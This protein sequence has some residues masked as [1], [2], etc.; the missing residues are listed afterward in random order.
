MRRIVASCVLLFWLSGQANAASNK[1]DGGARDQSA[2]DS[3]F[4]QGQDLFIQGQY[5]KAI[6]SFRKAYELQANPTFLLNIARAYERLQQNAQA[7][8]FYE[9]FLAVAD[10]SP[11][12]EQARGRL[13][14]LSELLNKTAPSQTDGAESS[15]PATASHQRTPHAQKPPV[16]RP[17]EKATDNRLQEMPPQR[18]DDKGP[19]A[20][21]WV[22]AG[23]L[24]LIG[25]GVAAFTLSGDDTRTPESELGHARFF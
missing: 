6:A 13:D 2:A 12:A 17:S 16:E 1:P 19:R 8:F 7:I 21:L 11:A 10:D 18:P 14:R 5:E 20:W 22:A 15:S 4:E 3:S 23:A 25:A 9:R 24:V